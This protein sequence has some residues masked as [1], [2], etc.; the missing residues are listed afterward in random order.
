MFATFPLI[1]IVKESMNRLI[2]VNYVTDFV[3]LMQ[4]NLV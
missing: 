4:A 3:L 1:D 2:V